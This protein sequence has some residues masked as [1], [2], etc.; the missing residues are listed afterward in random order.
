MSKF[1]KMVL[2]FSTIA[3]L[4]SSTAYANAYYQ[5]VAYEECRTAPCITPGVALGTV[6]AAAIIAILIQNRSGDH[7]H[8]HD[9]SCTSSSSEM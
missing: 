4:G 3:L 5:G 6:A 8:S 2:I 9:D 1:K 7:G